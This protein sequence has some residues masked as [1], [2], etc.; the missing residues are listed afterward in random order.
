MAPATFCGPINCLTRFTLEDL[1]L[2]AA[3]GVLNLPVYPLVWRAFF[4]CWS[5]F[6]A[7]V[8][9]WFSPDWLDRLRG[10][11][12]DA[13]QHTKLLAFIFLCTVLVASECLNIH[14]KLPALAATLSAW[15][16][17]L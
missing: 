14:R 15:V 4:G 5:D 13:W 7:A 9:F 16:S 17:Y 1:R 11:D 2:L 3:V 8:H 6:T 12:E 10:E